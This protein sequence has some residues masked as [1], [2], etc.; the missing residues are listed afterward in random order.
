MTETNRPICVV[1]IL[2][3]GDIRHSLG[4]E[5]VFLVVDKGAPH[6]RVYEMMVQ[7][8]REE[9]AILVGRSRIGTSPGAVERLMRWLESC[10]SR[11]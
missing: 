4:S 2:E 6:D 11:R 9:I 5:V 8:P 1:H 3:D 10:R 7:T